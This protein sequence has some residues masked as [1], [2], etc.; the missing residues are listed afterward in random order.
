MKKMMIYLAGFQF[1]NN[2]APA[3]EKKQLDEE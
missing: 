3:L 2:F 1:F